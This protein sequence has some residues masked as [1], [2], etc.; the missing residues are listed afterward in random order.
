M[1][2]RSNVFRANVDPEFS[3]ELFCIQK[4]FAHFFTIEFL[5]LIYFKHLL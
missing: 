5:P 3:G 1:R 4:I 2:F